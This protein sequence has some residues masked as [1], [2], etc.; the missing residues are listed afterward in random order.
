MQSIFIALKILCALPIHPALLYL[1][2]E[3]VYAWKY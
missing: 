1:I 2:K 3:K